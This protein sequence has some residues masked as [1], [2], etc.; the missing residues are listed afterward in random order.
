MNIKNLA[1]N[2]CLKHKIEPMKEIFKSYVYSYKVLNKKID[3]NIIKMTEDDF[4]NFIIKDHLEIKSKYQN[5]PN[6]GD[7]CNGNTFLG[8]IKMNE[9]EIISFIDNNN[10]IKLNEL[11]TYDLLLIKK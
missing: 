6:I 10:E 4:I 7:K 2:I 1:I 5:I 9:D 11:K 3:K 8:L